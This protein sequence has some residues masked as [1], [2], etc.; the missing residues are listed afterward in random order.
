MPTVTPEQLREGQDI[1]SLSGATTL[2]FTNPSASSYFFIEQN[3]NKN[4]DGS[5]NAGITSYTAGTFS[6]LTRIPRG[7]IV[8]NNFK[9]GVVIPPGDSSVIFTPT[10]TSGGGSIK[11]KG[12]GNATLTYS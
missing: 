6:S 9:F 5:F 12:T 10:D 7:G 3:T 4:S 2:S 1:S 11:L 8:E